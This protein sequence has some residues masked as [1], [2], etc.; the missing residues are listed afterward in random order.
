MK[1]IFRLIFFLLITV[2]F[3]LGYMTFFGLETKKFNNQIIKKI[4]DIDNSL[5]LELKEIKLIFDP[6][7]FSINA[8]TIG[9]KLRVRNKI[10]EI[11]NVK[12]QVS[13]KSLIN[14]QFSLENLE[15]SSKPLKIKDLISFIRIINNTPELYFLE[16]IIQRGYLI[17][18]IRV[19]F[20]EKGNIKNNY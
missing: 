18:D 17:T 10:I 14:D 16:K 4:K 9:P 5:E 7:S 19:D 8:K 11:E 15:I 12:T 2:I 6:M 20:D 1:I 13:V 3:L